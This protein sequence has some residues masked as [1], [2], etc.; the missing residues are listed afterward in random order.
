M[1]KLI[2]ELQKLHIIFVHDESIE[3]VGRL[4]KYIGLESA[5]KFGSSH[6]GIKNLFYGHINLLFQSWYKC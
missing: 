5:N 4:N 3:K 2:Y 6:Y 1:I